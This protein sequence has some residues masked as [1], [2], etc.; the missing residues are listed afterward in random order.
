MRGLESRTGACRAELDQCRF[1]GR[2][3]KATCFSGT[4]DK[5]NTLHGTRCQG[6]HQHGPVEGRDEDGNFHT[7]SLQ[8]YPVELCGVIAGL[9]HQTLKRFRDRGEGP[10]G[11]K[12]P[13][14]S[15]PRVTA[16]GRRGEHSE[17]VTVRNEDVVH[18]R[19]C[20]LR[21]GQKAFYLHVDDGVCAAD[22]STKKGRADH[23][24]HKLAD[25]LEQ[26]GF[27]VGDRTKSEDL[28]KIVG[29]TVDEHPAQLRLPARPREQVASRRRTTSYADTCVLR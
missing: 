10:G 19:G 6:G 29:Y 15:R 25:S 4:L 9:V 27:K 26:V 7:R 2:A 22:S 12:V 21:G 11:W 20:V 14:G 5:L 18:G 16:W 24:M 8:E 23:M 3:K 28:V 13:P 1:G 17:N